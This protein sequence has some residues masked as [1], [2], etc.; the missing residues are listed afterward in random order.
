MGG[1]TTGFGKPA[2][3]EPVKQP[4]PRSGLGLGRMTEATHCLSGCR[5]EAEQGSVVPGPWDLALTFKSCVTL[6]SVASST[7]RIYR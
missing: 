5:K 6:A 1:G 7:R 3:P 4:E 2:L